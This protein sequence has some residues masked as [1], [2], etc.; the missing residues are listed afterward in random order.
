MIFFDDLIF[1]NST[2][3]QNNFTPS[4]YN[5]VS[6][7]SYYEHLHIFEDLFAVKI[8]YTVKVAIIKF[9]NLKVGINHHL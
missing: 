2:S 8:L 3:L 4:P 9:V 7:P 5:V 1:H 6:L